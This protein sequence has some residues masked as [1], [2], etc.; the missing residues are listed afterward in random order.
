[1]TTAEIVRF[2]ESRRWPLSDEKRL[3]EYIW[4]EFIQLGVAADREVRLGDGDIIDFMIGDVGIEV[5]IKGRRMAI[6]RQC[7]RYCGHTAVASLVLAT[8][9]AMGMPESVK[10]KPVAIASLGRGWL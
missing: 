6:Y 3:Q 2:I 5:K 8:S 9:V 1:M 7:E 4:T 10:G